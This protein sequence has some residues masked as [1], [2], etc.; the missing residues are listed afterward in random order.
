VIKRRRIS[1][2]RVGYYRES[3]KNLPRK[4]EISQ[5]ILYY[6]ESRKN[7]PRKI[8]ISQEILMKNH[9]L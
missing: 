6:R 4:I 1:H 5:E 3:R 7:L 9:A 8:E 2:C